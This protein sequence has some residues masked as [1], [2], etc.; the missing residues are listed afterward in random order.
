MIEL[1]ITSQASMEPRS[2]K[3]G[4]EL[5]LVNLKLNT[6]ASMEPRSFKRGNSHWRQDNSARG[7]SLQWSHVLSN[8]ETP[9]ALQKLMLHIGGFNGATFF[10]T[11]KQR[12]SPNR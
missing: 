11:W 1:T 10:Q 8:V 9:I 2:F 5:M 3:R 7:K 4:N 6:G 12:E